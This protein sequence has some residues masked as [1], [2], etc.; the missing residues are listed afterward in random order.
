MLNWAAAKIFQTA[1]V[2]LIV[3]VAS[4]SLLKLA[5]GDPVMLMLGSEFS[6]ESYDELKTA[7]GL[8]RPV[9]ARICWAPTA[10]ARTFSAASSSGRAMRC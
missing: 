3:S 4:F 6:Q 8:D 2:L 5:P 7:L 1:V 9:A 10:T